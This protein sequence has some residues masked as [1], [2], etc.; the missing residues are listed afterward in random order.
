MKDDEVLKTGRNSSKYLPTGV[1]L[2]FNSKSTFEN[3]S[4]A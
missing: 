2:D 4:G 1:L 3:F